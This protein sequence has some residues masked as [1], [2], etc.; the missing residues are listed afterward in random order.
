M[1]LLTNRKT[2]FKIALA[3]AGET[4]AQFAAD[5]GCSR[6]Q[7]YRVLG[8]PT[9]GLGLSQHIDAFIAQYTRRTA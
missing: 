8:D 5:Y 4:A 3:L 9:Q 2:N 7:L 6:T 1:P